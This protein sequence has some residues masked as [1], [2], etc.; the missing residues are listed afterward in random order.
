MRFLADEHIPL[1]SIRL[2]REAGHEVESIAERAP[3]VEDASVLD[4]AR[5]RGRI[6]L[7]FDS[8]FG[9]LLFI[10]GRPPPLGVV[11][12]RFAQQTPTE[13]AQI[14]LSLLRSGMELEKR[15]TTVR[16]DRVRQRPLPP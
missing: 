5:R 1:P 15:F 12:L 11:Y 6:L 10:E 7:T 4:R 9:R 16:R 2:L 3:G 8:D 13:A 14:L